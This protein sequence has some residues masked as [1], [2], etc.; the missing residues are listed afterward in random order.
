MVSSFKSAVADK[1]GTF[2]FDGLPPGRYVVNAYFHRD[3]IIAIEP[4]TEVEVEPGGVAQVEIPL[5]RMPMIT[6]RVVDAR[7]GKGIAGVSLHSSW[8]EVGRNMVVGEATTDAEGGYKIAARPGRTTIEPTQMPKSHLGLDYGEIPIQ[9]VQAEQAWPDL[10]LLPAATLGGLVVNESGR[11]AV[12]A[13]VYLNAEGRSTDLT[14]D[15]IRPGPDGSFRV[16][17]LDPDRLMSLWARAGDATTDG[18]ITIRPREVKGTLTLTVDAKHA[19]GSAAR[20]PTSPASGLRAH[21]SRCGGIDRSPAKISRDGAD[22]AKACLNP[23][24]PMRMALSCSGASGRGCRMM[25]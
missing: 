10:E 6:G 21:R 7:T 18:T 16:D 22:H 14:G 20:R 17:Q 11:P 13:E 15:P 3:G 1:D 24:P 4:E 9:E 2:Q 19:A 23:R 12:G 5:R 25:S 8:H